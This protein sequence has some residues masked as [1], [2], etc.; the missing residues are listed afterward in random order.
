MNMV[1]SARACVCDYTSIAANLL[2][3]KSNNRILSQKIPL[4]KHVLCL[5]GTLFISFMEK[6]FCIKIHVFDL[7]QSERLP[8]LHRTE[9]VV[10]N[11]ATRNFALN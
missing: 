3:L 10:N 1:L 5:D 8:A 6:K 4:I 7:K 11:G 2:F 9:I